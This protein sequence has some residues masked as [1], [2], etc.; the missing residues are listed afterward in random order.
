MSNKKTD[1]KRII[2]NRRPFDGCIN[3]DIPK[4]NV[5]TRYFFSIKKKTD[6][7]PKGMESALGAMPMSYGK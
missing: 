4:N 5:D 2:A 6:K 1:P 3:V 7:K